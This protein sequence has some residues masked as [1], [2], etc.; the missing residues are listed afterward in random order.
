MPNKMRPIHPGEVLKDELAE[1]NLSANALA[2]ALGVPTNRITG[3]LN[4]NRAV[5][6]ETALRLARYFGTTAEF[7]MAL[8][9]AYDVK[10]A[11]QEAWDEIQRTVKPAGLKHAA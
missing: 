1:R 2:K 3:I 11:R 4:G 9:A 7:W 5:T 8:Q 10:R 6:A